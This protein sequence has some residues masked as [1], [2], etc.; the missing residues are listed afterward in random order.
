MSMA[1]A[2][3]RFCG[4]FVH[5]NRAGV[6]A[7]YIPDTL[8]STAALLD[9]TGSASFETEY[10]PYG[11][12]RSQSGSNTSP[13]GLVGLFGYFRDFADSLIYVRTRHLTPNRG[14]WLT[15]DPRWPKAK[16]FQYA[17]ANPIGEADPSGLGP[18]P[19]CPPLPRPLPKPAPCPVPNPLFGGPCPVGKN[20]NP[21]PIHIVLHWGWPPAQII[22]DPVYGKYCGPQTIPGSGPGVN[23]VDECCRVHDDCFADCDCT[24]WNQWKNRDCK[25]CNGDLCLCLE[26]AGSDVG[27]KS[28]PDCLL[29][30]CLFMQYACRFGV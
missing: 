25:C 12:G 24:A 2:Y 27:C 29:A 11:E 5:E 22:I 4:P 6:R 20:W 26:K 23:A 7:A 21:H 28:D 15:A 19:G 3:S 8:G 10:W 13:W 18:C 1:V 14:L 16:A 30:R 17:I 9:H